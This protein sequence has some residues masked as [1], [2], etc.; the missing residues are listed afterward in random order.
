MLWS[1]SIRKV[2]GGNEASFGGGT[3]NIRQ[4]YFAARDVEGA[5]NATM[6]GDLGRIICQ[7]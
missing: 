4:V 3:A 7:M 2:H 6:K 1:K 5:D